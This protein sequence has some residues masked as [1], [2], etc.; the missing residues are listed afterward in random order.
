M[1][2]TSGVMKT[3]QYCN[4]THFR[5]LHYTKHK[6]SCCQLQL[7]V[8]EQQ[9]EAN[10]IRSLHHVTFIRRLTISNTEF[11]RIDLENVPALVINE[12]KRSYHLIWHTYY[13][14]STKTSIKIN[15][16]RKHVKTTLKQLHQIF[17]CFLLPKLLIK[18]T[19]Y[20][21]NWF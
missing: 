2:F 1:V 14:L 21:R 15:T 7:T 11:S 17:Y 19:S 12:V 10:Y 20:C 6:R 9:T 13:I 3:C 8:G 5:V 4:T 18:L 16:W